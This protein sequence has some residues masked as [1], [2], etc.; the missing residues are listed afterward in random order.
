[1]RSVVL[2][3]ALAWDRNPA[4]QAF[5]EKEAV[6]YETCMKRAD[7]VNEQATC[8]M[9]SIKRCMGRGLEAYCGNRG[10]W[11]EHKDG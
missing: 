1:M 2:I 10:M 3:M 7:S 8:T 4:D 9:D 5:R 11:L 6:K